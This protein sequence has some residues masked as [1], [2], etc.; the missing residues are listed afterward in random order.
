MRKILLAAMLVLCGCSQYQVS[1]V[2]TMLGEI[3]Q[4]TD[5]VKKQELQTYY[6]NVVAGY[7]AVHDEATAG[8]PCEVFFDLAMEAGFTPDQW[9]NPMSRIMNAESGCSPTA[10]NPSGATG[11]MQIMPMWADDCGGTVS[12]LYDPTF[13]INCAKHVYDIQG[14]PAWSTY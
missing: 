9:K 10:H 8:H 14:W 4:Q 13:N 1:W 2:Q 6:D 3:A 12:D 11:L 5:P 7:Q